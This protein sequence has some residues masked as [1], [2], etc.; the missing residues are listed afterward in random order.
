MKKGDKLT[1]K[2]ALELLLKGG[3]LHHALYGETYFT[4]GKEG[5]HAGHS[6]DP[7]TRILSF[8]AALKLLNDESALTVGYLGSQ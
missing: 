3:G 5:L 6:F 4:I 2:E 7:G 1:T 8:H